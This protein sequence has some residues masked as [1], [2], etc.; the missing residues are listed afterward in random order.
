[1]DEDIE[2]VEGSDCRGVAVGVSVIGRFARDQIPR[3]IRE[4]LVI[5]I[6]VGDMGKTIMEVAVQN[7]QETQAESGS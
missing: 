7:K 5:D 3:R 4:H 6:S 2:G 1:M